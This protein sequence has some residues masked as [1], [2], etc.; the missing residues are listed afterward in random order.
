MLEKL[1]KHNYKCFTGEL[2][3]ILQGLVHFSITPLCPWGYLQ[4]VKLNIRESQNLVLAELG[5]YHIF[6]YLCLATRVQ[7]NFD[8]NLSQ[9]W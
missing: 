3:S 7:S 1:L 4:C 8:F 6:I 5:Q 2:V 9:V